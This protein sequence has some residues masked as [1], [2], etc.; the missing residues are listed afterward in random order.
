[1][2]ILK[3]STENELF[4]NNLTVTRETWFSRKI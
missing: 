2:M 3:A 1:M 4:S